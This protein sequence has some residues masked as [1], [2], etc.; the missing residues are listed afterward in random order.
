MVCPLGGWRRASEPRN[1]IL[2]E[3]AQLVF[4]KLEGDFHLIFMKIEKKKA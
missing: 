3:L 4:C 2:K 1:G